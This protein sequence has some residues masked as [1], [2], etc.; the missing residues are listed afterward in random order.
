VADAKVLFALQKVQEAFTRLEKHYDDPVHWQTINALADLIQTRGTIL[1][2][3]PD[4]KAITDTIERLPMEQ[5]IATE[6][7]LKQPERPKLVACD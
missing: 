4:V 7:V 6:W 3:D 1:G 5:E 2:T